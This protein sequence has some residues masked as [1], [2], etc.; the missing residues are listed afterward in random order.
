VRTYYF[1]LERPIFVAHRRDAFLRLPEGWMTPPPGLPADQAMWHRFLQPW[2]RAKFLRWPIALHF[3]APDRLDRSLDRRGE[4]LRHWTQ[5]I[6]SP[7]YAVRATSRRTSATG[8]WARAWGSA[9]SAPRPY[10]RDGRHV[11]RRADPADRNGRPPAGQVEAHQ[12]THE[13]ARVLWAKREAEHAELQAEHNAVLSSTCWRMTAPLRQ[14]F[15]R[16]RRFGR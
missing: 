16:I 11:G 10:R 9:S 12:A 5:I 2:C 15:D 7:D 3:P 8:C 14:A 13:R 6:E 4:E 1:D